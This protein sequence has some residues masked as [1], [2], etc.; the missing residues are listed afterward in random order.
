MCC[1]ARSWKIT[2]DHIDLKSGCCGYQRDT[3]YTSRIKDLSY[4]SNCC[5]DVCCCGRG[6]VVIH[7]ADVSHPELQLTTFGAK[8]IYKSLQGLQQA[9]RHQNHVVMY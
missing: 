7:S 6:T 1:V 5:L 9:N 3:L 2:Q 4:S 8:A